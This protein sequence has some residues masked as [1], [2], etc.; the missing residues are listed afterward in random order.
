MAVTM[1]F[2]GCSVVVVGGTSGIN[3][4]IAEGFARHGA[5]V[6]V[7]SRSQDKVDDTVAALT[8]A[9]AARA[10]GAAFDVRDP[11]AVADGLAGFHGAFGDFDIVISGAAGNFP[12]LAAEMSVNAFRTVIEI[13]LMGTIHVMK[14]AYP[15]LKRPGA[16][17]INISAPQAFLPF[18]GQAHVCAAKAG[19]D[20]ITRTLALEW[21]VEGIRV[22]SVVPGYIDGT[23][24]AQ[25]L[26]PTEAARQQVIDDIALGRM[27]TLA[28]MANICQFLGSDLASYLTGQ[29]IAVDGALTQRGSGQGGRQMGEMLR[30]MPPRNKC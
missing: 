28:D 24:G 15:F 12:A 1:D 7:A 5:R 26:A 11:Q 23:E 14:A 9:G 19:V 2:Q 13:D 16:S 10:T 18:E 22:N 3:R 29:V 8:R 20:Q 21:G 30:A 6:A 17:V 27:G 4:G 25:R